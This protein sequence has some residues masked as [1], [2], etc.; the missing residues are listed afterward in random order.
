MIGSHDLARLVTLPNGTSGGWCWSV[1]P[2]SCKRSGR[3]GLFDELRRNGR[4]HQLEQI[5]RFT[6][7]WEAKASLLLRAGDPRALDVYEAHGRIIPGTLEEHL[8]EI[9]KQW[10]DRHQNGDTVALVA[11]SNDHVDL[12][13]AAVQSL[14]LTVG[15][16][17]PDTAVTIAGG[18]HAHV[19][20]VVATRR[21]NRQ[22]VTSRR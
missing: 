12:L 2:A 9:A 6:H 14:R 22:L 17:D 13:N 16:L 15:D 3:G 5:H 1:T 18:E 11:S 8:G 19:G 10:V 20:D 4:V 21:N 7:P